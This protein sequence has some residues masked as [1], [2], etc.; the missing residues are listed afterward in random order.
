M[1]VSNASNSYYI[2]FR[3]VG[4]ATHPVNAT[5]ELALKYAAA[6]VLLSAQVCHIRP[7]V[8]SNT[9]RAVLSSAGMRRV[10][11]LRKRVQ[12]E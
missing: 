8:F 5:L 3:L 7:L 4:P 1:I 9:Q 10:L 11:C 2:V 12:M 6:S